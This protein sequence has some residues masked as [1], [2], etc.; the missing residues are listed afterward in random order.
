MNDKDK[1]AFEKWRN[2]TW[3]LFLKGDLD[4]SW[5][6]ACEYKDREY[7]SGSVLKNMNEKYEQEVEKNKRL[8]SAL[9]EIRSIDWGT[10]HCDAKNMI[11]DEILMTVRGEA[12]K[13]IK[14]E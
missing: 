4:Q 2:N 12:L 1:E 7:L 10:D 3:D 5:Q 11:A 14:G 6:A 13:E 8:I 9:E